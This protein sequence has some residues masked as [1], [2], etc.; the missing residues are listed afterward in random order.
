MR[1]EGIM[2]TS[3]LSVQFIFP[4]VVCGVCSLLGPQ[5]PPATV[6]PPAWPQRAKPGFTESE[7]LRTSR[8]PLDHK[9]ETQKITGQAVLEV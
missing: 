7:P 4:P 1:S 6:A 3:G 9:T 2:V 8:T 5:I